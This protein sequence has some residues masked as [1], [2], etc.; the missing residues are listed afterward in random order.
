MV[1]FGYGYYKPFLSVMTI[2]VLGFILAATGFFI[3]G[4]TN[5]YAMAIIGAA[6]SGFGLGAFMPNTTAWLMRITPQRVRGRV[7]GGFTSTF[8]FG[9]FIS[10]VVVAPALLWLD[11]LRS[12]FVAMAVLCCLLALILA[13]LGQTYLKADAKL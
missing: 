7:F 10:P 5:S 4:L 2:Y 8:F 13:L 1:A 11:T 3:V 9:Q 6:V 12:V